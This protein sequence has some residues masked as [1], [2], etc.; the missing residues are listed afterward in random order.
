MTTFL[1]IFS[2]RYVESAKEELRQLP[3][4]H[5]QWIVDEVSRQLAREPTVQTRRRKQ[6]RGVG[7]AIWQ[8]R[9]GG[10]RVFY[11]IDAAKRNVTVRAI[12]RKGRLRTEEL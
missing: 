4:F 9:I 12:R 10:F 8:L 2:V 5:R 1:T 7:T 3:S 6:L 11:D